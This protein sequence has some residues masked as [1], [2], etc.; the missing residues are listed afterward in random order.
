MLLG[1]LG[2]E[3]GLFTLHLGEGLF[4]LAHLLLELSVVTSRGRA[5]ATTFGGAA[6]S[7]ALDLLAK[8]T[9]QLILG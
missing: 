5:A 1:E 7:E 9:D 3:L 4:L 6:L 2:L 8:L